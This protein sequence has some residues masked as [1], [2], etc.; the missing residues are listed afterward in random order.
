MLKAIYADVK[1]CIKNFIRSNWHDVLS[2]PGCIISPVSF[3]LF[4]NDLQDFIAEGSPCIDLETIKIFV[5]LF[6]DDLVIFAEIAI[7]LQRLINK[8]A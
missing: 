2:C 8:L 6:A 4:L 5:L 3:T 1:T 7:E